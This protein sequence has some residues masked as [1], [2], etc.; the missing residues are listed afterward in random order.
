V[1]SLRLSDAGAN[2]EEHG[3]TST[4]AAFISL[5]GKD[6]EKLQLPLE[7][8]ATGLCS[9]NLRLKP[10]PVQRGSKRI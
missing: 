1:R 9:P 3:L 4:D 8:R 10:E 7:N 5:P 6:S 2:A